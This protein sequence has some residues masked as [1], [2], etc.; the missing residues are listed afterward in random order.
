MYPAA[1]R[2]LEHCDAV[3]RLPGE[4]AGADQDVAIARQD[5]AFRSMTGSRTSPSARPGPPLRASS[6]AGCHVTGSTR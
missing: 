3:L 6:V 2:L 4:S 5:A 1:Q